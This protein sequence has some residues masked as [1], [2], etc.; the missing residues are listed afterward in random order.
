MLRESI[1]FIAVPIGR[2]ISSMC[3]NY[4]TVILLFKNLEI[5]H[6]FFSII[7]FFD[8][9]FFLFS[10]PSR[11]FFLDSIP[12]GCVNNKILNHNFY[13]LF[14]QPYE[15]RHKF[16]YN[17]YISIPEV[18]RLFCPV[19]HVPIFSVLDRPPLPFCD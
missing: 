16:W 13:Y 10:Y 9:R 3:K 2:L 4:W 11:Y 5:F 15:C 8:F 19:G 7:I 1:M 18:P 6:S 12:T 17:L 14:L